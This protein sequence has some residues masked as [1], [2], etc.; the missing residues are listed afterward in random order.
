MRDVN[1]LSVDQIIKA[2]SAASTKSR[3]AFIEACPA[4]AMKEQALLAAGMDSPEFRAQALDFL[5]AGYAASGPYDVGS[6]IAEACCRLARR[7][8]ERGVGSRDVCRMI[9]GRG[10]LNWM[11]CLQHLGRHS[12]IVTLIREPV[13]WLESIGDSDNLDMLRLKRVEAEL[14]R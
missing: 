5:A 3:A 6:K 7:D 10:A 2:M 14:D 13:Q 1:S 4:A 8:Y 11:T 12:E 9:A